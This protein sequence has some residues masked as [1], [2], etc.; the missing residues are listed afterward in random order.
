MNLLCMLFMKN[1]RKN[2][3]LHIYLYV[4]YESIVYVIG[5]KLRRVI[6]FFFC[7]ICRKTVKNTNLPRF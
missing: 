7:Y 5:D 3:N 2:H 1:Y 6:R 4:N